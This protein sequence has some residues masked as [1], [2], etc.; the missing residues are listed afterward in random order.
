MYVLHSQ[1]LRGFGPALAGRGKL[2]PR[3]SG[4][5]GGAIKRLAIG[6]PDTSARQPALATPLSRS[7]SRML[8]AGSKCRP[9][10]ASATPAVE[11]GAGKV[12]RVRFVRRNR[13]YQVRR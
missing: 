13:Q 1:G 6:N 11:S 3:I 9:L 8:T 10:Q 12:L 4:I 5:S 7:C 2:A